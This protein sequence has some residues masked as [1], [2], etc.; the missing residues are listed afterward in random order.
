M[1]DFLELIRV[2]VL[3]PLECEARA[4]EMVMLSSSVHRRPSHRPVDLVMDPNMERF[5]RFLAPNVSRAMEP[6]MSHMERSTKRT[7]HS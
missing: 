5:G 1:G 3:Q 2:G 6:M 4:L 7:T